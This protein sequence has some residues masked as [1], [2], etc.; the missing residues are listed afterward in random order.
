MKP[1]AILETGQPPAALADRYDDYPA[2][3]RALLG[4]GTETVRFDVQAGKLPEDPSAFQAALIELRRGT[5]I[6]AETADKALT[7][8]YRGDD[9]AVLTAWIR[10]FLLLTPPPVEDAG[11]GI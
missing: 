4:E 8:L 2:R 7:T 6:D 3:F 9:R 5:R 1:I 10:A 11:S